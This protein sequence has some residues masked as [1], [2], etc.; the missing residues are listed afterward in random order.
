MVGVASPVP[1][2]GQA[3]KVLRA[4]DHVADAAKAADHSADAVNIVKKAVEPTSTMKTLSEGA[5][6]SIRPSP[7]ANSVLMQLIGATK[8]CVN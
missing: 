5:T 6:N 7:T 8:W 2:A 4:A 3:L 1:G